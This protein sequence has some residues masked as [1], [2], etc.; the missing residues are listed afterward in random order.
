MRILIQIQTDH[1]KNNK[2]SKG[3]SP[4]FPKYVKLPPIKKLFEEKRIYVISPHPDDTA[5][6]CG[7]F[8][9]ALSRKNK[10]RSLVL[11]SGSH[12]ANPDVRKKETILEAE[13]LGMEEPLFLDLPF[14]EANRQ[15]N[16]LDE[17]LFAAALDPLP[18]M[19]FLPSRYDSHKT[20]KTATN[21]TF[22]IL[23]KA[24]K[25]KEKGERKGKVEVIFY[26]TP[27]GLFPDGKFNAIFPIDAETMRQK[28][29]AIRVH[30]SQ[31]ERTQFATF[32]KSLAQLRAA[33]V[34]ELTLKKWG[35]GQNPF[36]LGKYLEVYA[37]YSRRER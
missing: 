29:E 37:F 1:N 9:A 3:N 19:I 13:V 16:F 31:I 33:V 27:W 14:Y 28:L 21:L 35:F 10:T 17:E 23:D 20:H 8:I 24:L 25:S 32:A 12:V 34:P 7:A 18:D 11:T 22:Q 36:E 30:Q 6:G 4:K 5:V 2:N 15:P 26:E